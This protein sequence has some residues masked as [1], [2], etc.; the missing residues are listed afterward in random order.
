MKLR[1]RVIKRALDV[2]VSATGLALTAP[3]IAGTGLVVWAT[4]GRPV[5]FRQ[6]RPGHRG[7]PFE[8]IKFRTMRI[9]ARDSVAND[10]VRLTAVG[11]LLRASSLDELPTLWNTLRG[12]MSLVGPRPLL[13]Q[14][15]DRYSPEQFRRHDV[16]PGITGWAQING[17][18]AINWDEKFSLDVWYVDHQS[19]ALDLEI[20]FKTAT[21]VVQREGISHPGQATM[22]EFMGNDGDG[23]R[24]DEEEG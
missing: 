7:E 1:E 18:N 5:L 6:R 22:A 13:M 19:L 20:L 2:A 10:G 23:H 15:L 21:K 4:M 17:R 12:D 3:V 11:R 16:K 24:D 8:L 14:Y 9:T